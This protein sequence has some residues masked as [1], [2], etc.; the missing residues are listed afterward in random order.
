MEPASR[1]GILTETMVQLS[2]F[3]KIIYKEPR[4]YR[5]DKPMQKII[6]FDSEAYRNGTTFMYCTSLGDCIAPHELIEKLFTDKYECANFVVWN[7]KYESGAILKLFPRQTLKTLQEELTVECEYKGLL[8]ILSYVPHK[9]LKI[10]K[11]GGKTVRFWDM[12]PF[13]GRIKLETAAKEYLR[14]SKLD[15]DSELFTIEYAAEHFAEISAYCIQDAMLTQRLATLWIGKFEQTGIMVT[16]LYSEASISWTYI[17]RKNDIVTPW[18]FWYTNKRLLRFAFE[19]YEGGK[20][21]VTARGRF[22][23][24]EYDISSAYPYE[25]ANLVDIRNAHIVHGKKYVPEAVYGF[26]RV[27]IDVRDPHVHLPCGIF[28]KL[29][30]Y[31]V[32]TYYL[33]I[34]KQEYDYI[35][36][37]L[38]NPKVEVE[39]LDAE[40][41]VKFC[42]TY[43]YR[44]IMQEIYE[45][46]TYWKT[47]DRF[48]SNNYKIIANGFYGKM[49]QCIEDGEGNYRAGLGWNPVYASVITANT[50]IAVTRLQNLLGSNCYAV[51]TDSVISTKPIPDRF[52]GKSL[53][54]FELVEQG[55]GIIIACGIYEING[56]FSLKGFSK[57]CNR[58]RG[59]GKYRGETCPA[60]CGSGKQSIKNLLEENPGKKKIPLTSLHVESWLQAMAQNHATARINLF[61]DRPKDLKLNCDTKRIWENEVDSDDLLNS[62]QFS[63]PLTEQQ[64][65]QPEYWV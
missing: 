33:T 34:T 16:S 47:R 37:E 5:F 15:M 54:D 49:A 61:S 45:Q 48:R 24:Y 60:C 39:I 3:D 46:K 10:K 20:F 31:P 4:I 52:I 9:Q 30:L 11:V 22:T 41:M 36:E 18:E 32:G 23:G 6:G 17:S 26:L 65:R 40:W 51:H 13:Y 19:S 63:T 43:P 14:E 12:S 8:Y 21:E 25:I 28:R 53:G 44:G 29:R 64:T 56:Q 59:S 58:C 7:I 2:N 42:T 55:D 38:A 50:R 57:K 1:T 62:L 27:R 35:V